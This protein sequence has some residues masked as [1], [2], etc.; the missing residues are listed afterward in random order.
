LPLNTVSNADA[1]TGS[2]FF[3]NESKVNLGSPL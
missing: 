3:S 1:T 2:I